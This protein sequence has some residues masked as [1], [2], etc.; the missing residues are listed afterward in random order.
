MDD[1]VAPGADVTNML[2]SDER[3]KR[4]STFG[5]TMRHDRIGSVA[6][7]DTR[8]RTR[9]GT[10]RDDR[11]AQTS[12]SGF[13]QTEVTWTPHVRTL[14]G[15]RSDVYRFGV[16]SDN[17]LNSGTAWDGLVSPK[18]SLIVDPWRGTE[19]YLNGGFGFHS[20]DARGAVITVD[21][22]SGERVDPVTPL[23]RARAA[24]VGIRTVRIPAVQTSVSFWTLGLDSELIFVGDAGTTEAT[25]TSRR[26]GVEWSSYARVRRW[27]TVDADLA[28]SRARFTD[29]DAAGDRI[30]GA[31][32]RVMGFGA[33]VDELRGAFGSVRVRYVGPRALIED[34]SI[35]SGATALVNAEGG[36]QVSRSARLV[37]DAFN[38][39]DAKH[40]DI[41]CFYTSRLLGE[42]EEGVDDIHSHPTAPRTVRLSLRVGF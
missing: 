34:D 5:G 28:F 20:N 29:L 3:V 21:P 12:M 30:P 14:A 23:A 18:G 6:L 19:L 2:L 17:T 32:N 25:R 24:E 11:V 22:A 31:V 10:T 27:L 4:E 37:L 39:F 42:A 8:A 40:S 7:Y 15:L 16:A 35:R 33:A 13:A 36:Y 41:D 1:L 38:L 26:Y 9:L